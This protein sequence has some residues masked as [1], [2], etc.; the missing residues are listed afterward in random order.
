MGQRLPNRSPA[1]TRVPGERVVAAVAHLAMA[2]VGLA[3]V[4]GL[5]SLYVWA[6]LVVIGH[7]HG[8]VV[9]FLGWCLVVLMAAIGIASIAGSAWAALQHPSIRQRLGR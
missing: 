5:G 7:L 6:I 4:A 3:T 1:A 9:G 2:T 8:G